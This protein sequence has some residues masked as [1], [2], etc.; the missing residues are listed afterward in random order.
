MTRHLRPSGIDGTAE[1]D[2]TFLLRD[3][4]DLAVGRIVWED[5]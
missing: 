5:E 1:R 4:P 2:L 3:V